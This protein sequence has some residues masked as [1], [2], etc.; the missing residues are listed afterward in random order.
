MMGG[1]LTSRDTRALQLV[2]GAAAVLLV[3]SLGLTPYRAAAAEARLE[4]EASRDQLQREVRL[5]AGGHSHPAAWE[6]GAARMLEVA[7]RLFGGDNDG[8]ASAALTGYIHGAA[9]LARVLVVQL[10]PL[11]SEHA[12]G[13]ITAL[14]LR[15]RG[16]SDLEGL[17]A[18]LEAIE[19]GPKLV[20]IDELQVG[21]SS[22]SAHPESL[23]AEVLSFH[24]T[25]AGFALDGSGRPA[26]DE[27]RPEEHAP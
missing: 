27:Q 22:A 13:G 17:L 16:E 20:R 6:R 24:L 14:P 9:K 26:G 5:L 2:G 10:E 7:P 19:S 21:R 11:P 15:L 8:A 1:A 3:W 12:G 18:L 23:D 4:L 25:L